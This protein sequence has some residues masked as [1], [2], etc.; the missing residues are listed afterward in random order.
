MSDYRPRDGYGRIKE[1]PYRRGGGYDRERRL[2]TTIA[3]GAVVL[4]LFGLGVGFALG[5][6]T[7]PKASLT[8]VNDG[9]IIT[10]TT[11]MPV[12]V[13]EETTDTTALETTEETDE[14]STSVETT[15]DTQP[16]TTPRQLEPANGA[17]LSGPRTTLSWSKST[18]DSDEPVTYAFEIQNRAS[19][20]TYGS[21]QVITG[22]KSRSYQARVIAGVRRRWRVW[23]VDAAG[24]TSAKTGWRYYRGKVVTPTGST[25]TSST[26]TSDTSN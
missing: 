15:T 26:A 2:Q 9:A 25:N 19:D 14:A 24:N 13:A 5:R 4:L 12:D 8:P 6:S 10:D 11:T 7:A 3:V 18:D 1:R 23:A 17:V 20:G 21:A 22:L 16:P